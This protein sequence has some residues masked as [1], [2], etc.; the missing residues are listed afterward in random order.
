MTNL[1]VTYDEMSSA[2]TQLSNGMT[3]VDNT[4]QQ[5]Q[6]LVQQ[7]VGGGYVTDQ[8]SKQFEASYTEFHNGAKQ[9]MQGL[10]GMSS[11]LKSAVSAFTEVDQQ[12]STQLRQQ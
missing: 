3:E 2:A 6:T 11:Y 1:N 8:S 10:G 7:L 9:V 5:L 12:L 4:L